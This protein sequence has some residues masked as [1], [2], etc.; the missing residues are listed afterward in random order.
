MIAFDIRKF[1]AWIFVITTSI[2]AISP[3]LF[4]KM[5]IPMNPVYFK[6]NSSASCLAFKS[7]KINRQ[8]S[9][10]FDKAMAEASPGSKISEN[11]LMLLV[12]LGS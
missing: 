8:S 1:V 2:S 5:S 12:F 6:F 3:F 4:A 11:A 9:I 7:S 10:S